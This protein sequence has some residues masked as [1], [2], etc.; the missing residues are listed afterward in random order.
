MYEA[1]TYALFIVFVIPASALMIRLAFQEL[2]GR[3]DLYTSKRV[4][5]EQV[6]IAGDDKCRVPIDGQLQNLVVFGVVVE[7]EDGPHD[8]PPPE[9]RDVEEQPPDGVED[10]EE[11]ED[12]SND[13]PPPEGKD[14]EEQ[15]REG[16][17]EGRG[18][19]KRLG[20]RV[21]FRKRIK[22][23]KERDQFS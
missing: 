21:A 16:V 1:A 18:V 14:V 11:S 3:Y 7:K 23:R 22:R 17:E 10:V 4:Q 20:R 8:A 9:G 12:G 15:P 5:N 6:D 19:R 13:A 2:G